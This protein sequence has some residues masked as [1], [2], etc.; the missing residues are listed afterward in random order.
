MKPKANLQL[1]SRAD[2]TKEVARRAVA[3]HRGNGGLADLEERVA[4]LR[5]YKRQEHEESFIWEPREF[6]ILGLT[7][8]FG[9]RRVPGIGTVAQRLF[10]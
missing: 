8:T 5:G 1:V 3:K 10:R 4:K 2:E 6:K 7:F 9:T